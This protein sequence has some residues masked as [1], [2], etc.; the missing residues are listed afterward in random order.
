M[1]DLNKTDNEYQS[2][3]KDLRRQIAQMTIRTLPSFWGGLVI[4]GAPFIAYAIAYIL[5]DRY[6]GQAIGI[7]AIVPVIIAAWFLGQHLGSMA[8]LLIFPVN[9]IL[10][11]ILGQP[12]STLLQ[13]SNLALMA[14]LVLIASVVGRQQHL[15]DQLRLGLKSSLKGEMEFWGS[16]ERYQ[17]LD[18]AFTGIAVTDSIER[19]M[20]C[21]ATLADMLGYV[22]DEFEDKFLDQFMEPSEI[23]KFRENINLMKKGIP[24][25]YEVSM[26]RKDGD[27]LTMLFSSIPRFAVDG[28]YEG[29]LS[30]IIDI[31]ERV[32]FEKDL[33]QSEERFRELIEKA[34]IGISIDDVEGNLVYINQTFADI[35]GY[36]IEEIHEKPF[37][38]LTHPDDIERVLGYHVA[39]IQGQEAPSRYEYRGIRK[40]GSIIHLEVDVVLLEEGGRATGTRTYL[41]DISE[42]KHAEVAIKD[43]EERFRRMS[44]VA[45]EGI[46][47]H[48]KGNIID[49]N[50]AFADMFGYSPSELIGMNALD[51]ATEELREKASQAISTGS[52]EIYIGGAVRK[53]G[54]ILQV[55]VQGRNIP[56]EGKMIRAVAVREITERM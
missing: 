1:V 20:Y 41:W 40:D 6:F 29:I 37:Q 8:A 56:F 30:V 23:S 4:I 14:S 43:S 39:R 44:E 19:L 11:L 31:T 48:D 10:L 18:T 45:F 47:I 17:A 33:K 53:D 7:L 52:E 21:N 13:A 15:V 55:E 42:R 49:V 5:T 51:F 34:G 46:L 26:R 9:M 32:R 28:S 24:T 22:P 25:K 27:H 35:H 2:K 38:S 54:S 16:R 3:L 36:T 50:T 12:L